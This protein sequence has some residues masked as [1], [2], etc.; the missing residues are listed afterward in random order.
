[1]SKANVEVSAKVKSREFFYKTLKAVKLYRGGRFRRPAIEDEYREGE[2]SRVV[3]INYRYGIMPTI[4][5]TGVTSRRHWALPS[6]SHECIDKVVDMRDSINPIYQAL[7]KSSETDELSVWK[8]WD[9]V[10]NRL[11]TPL[12]F[13]IDEYKLKLLSFYFYLLSLTTEFHRV[14]N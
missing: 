10:K 4:D 8:E 12:S 1:M 7:L 11:H 14:F 5:S 9:S 3:A 6:V 2:E 13:F